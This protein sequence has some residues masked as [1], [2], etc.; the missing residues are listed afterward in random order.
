MMEIRLWKVGLCTLVAFV[1]LGTFPLVGATPIV[2]PGGPYVG[3]E[4]QELKFDAS[5]TVDTDGLPL[6]YRWDFNDDGVYDTVYSSNP[7]TYHT[8]L[9]DFIG[10]CRLEVRNSSGVEAS[11]TAAVRISNVDPA[12][13]DIT[14]PT[15]PVE[16]GSAVYISADFFDGDART[17][18]LSLDPL[19]VT[20]TW[21][22]GAITSIHLPSGSTTTSAT[23]IYSAPAVYNVL[24]EITDDDGG[25]CSATYMVV[26]Y[27]PNV[28][29]GTGFVTGGGWIAT[30]A[31][32]Y[33]PD[34]SI[35]GTANFG[36]V[37]KYKKG[38]TIPDGN[39]EFNFQE[40]DLNFHA[41]SYDWLTVSGAV[42]RYRGTGT[43][44]GAGVYGFILTATDGKLN[45]GSDAFR[46]QIWDKFSGLIV[47]DNNINQVID[48]G[49]I[50]I[51][52]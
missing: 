32:N 38:Q 29:P 42:A 7:V 48:G 3:Y 9:D 20:F 19:T 2:A 15:A 4:C 45:G 37:S 6:E 43:I 21:A 36:F 34:P 27:E 30:A 46:I 12:I 26:V 18:V 14:G 28:L 31:G 47:F 40:A 17:G 52:I 8:Y 13:T 23:H 11:D 33:R 10:N 35:T 25:Y 49:Q 50:V 22:D 51:H 24:V 16:V 44:N 1:F 39:T 5:E 41:Q